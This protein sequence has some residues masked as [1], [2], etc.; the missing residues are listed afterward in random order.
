MQ[1]AKTH[2][3]AGGELSYAAH[4]SAATGTQMRLSVFTPGG[5]GPFPYLIWLSGLTCTEDNFTTK[6]GAYAAAAKHGVAIVAP[7]TSPRGEGVADDVA[8]DLGQGAS[9]YIDATGAVGAALQDGNL[10]RP[11]SD[12]SSGSE[13]STRAAPF[14]LWPFDGRTG[15]AAFGAARESLGGGNCTELALCGIE[16]AGAEN[17][18]DFG[19]VEITNIHKK[20]RGVC[21]NDAPS[22]HISQY[23]LIR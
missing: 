2:R 14:D 4:E 1:V 20:K 23:S 9:F 5:N 18:R 17:Q 7:D 3:V 16:H 11:R 22:F 12:R 21:Q 6:A 19:Q 13:L 8:Y 15:D 10:C